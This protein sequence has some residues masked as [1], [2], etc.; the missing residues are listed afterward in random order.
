MLLNESVSAFV[1]NTLITYPMTL[2]RKKTNEKKKVMLC[3]PR[4]VRIMT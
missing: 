2:S 1:P 3:W 4:G